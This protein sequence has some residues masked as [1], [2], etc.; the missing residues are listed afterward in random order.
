M[1]L[2][3]CSSSFSVIK[4]TGWKMF[5]K[6]IGKVRIYTFFLTVLVCGACQQQLQPNL[7]P[8]RSKQGMAV[9]AHPLASAAGLALLQQG[10]NAVDAAA[11]TALAISG[12]GPLFAGSGA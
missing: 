5:S 7:Q 4:Q 1:P 12:A 2:K 8:P 11:A 3:G 10:G 9:A 6:L